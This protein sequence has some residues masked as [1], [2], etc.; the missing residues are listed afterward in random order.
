[1]DSSNYRYTILLIKYF[2]R[3]VKETLR[4]VHARYSLPKWQTVKLTFFTPWV[5]LQ[6][7]GKSLIIQKWIKSP[8]KLCRVIVSHPLVL[9]LIQGWLYTARLTFWK[10]NMCEKDLTYHNVH[11]YNVGFSQWVATYMYNTKSFNI[12]ASA[13]NFFSVI[14]IFFTVIKFCVL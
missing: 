10:A 7:G 9:N 4:L 6:I 12:H 13:N 8:I 1:M 14:W 3:A 2:F 5:P 11:M